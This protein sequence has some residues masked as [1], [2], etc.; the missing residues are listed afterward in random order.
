M[1]ANKLCV[2]LISLLF[3]G[4]AF[5]DHCDDLDAIENEKGQLYGNCYDE[6]AAQY[7]PC[8]EACVV[9]CGDF[10]CSSELNE[11][12]QAIANWN[13]CVQ[14]ST[15]VSGP[16]FVGDWDWGDSFTVS[17]HFNKHA[18]GYMWNI[19]QTIYCSAISVVWWSA[20]I[21]EQALD[22]CIVSVSNITQD[23]V[24]INVP[25]WVCYLWS[26]SNDAWSMTFT[27]PW[28]PDPEPE[29]DPESDP[30]PEIECTTPAD[31]NLSCASWWWNYYYDQDIECC[32]EG[33]W[34]YN[35][36]DE[37]WNCE[38][39]FW[40]DENNCCAIDSC[41]ARPWE[42]WC[43]PWFAQSWDCCEPAASVCQWE[44]QYLPDGW[45]SASDCTWCTEW[46]IPNSNHTKCVCDSSVKCC[47]IQLNTVVP[48]IWDCIE[49]DT[50]SSRWDTTSVNSV[51]AFPI[52]MQWLMKILMSVIM[53][54]SFIMVIV[55][56]L[57]MTAWAFKSSSFDKWK[58]ILKN[59][60]I[61]LILLWCSW[62]ILSLI[63]PSFFGG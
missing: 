40:P 21:N 14:N 58:S 63:N 42:S 45:T 12:N 62:L 31:E 34:C 55:S 22:R 8:D 27:R 10:V 38:A 39:G 15:W 56:W 29:P 28:E 50:D 20:S 49:L 57:M 60:L 43:Q 53:V 25:H 4:F 19:N 3:F 30:E 54:F 41:S 32:V 13:N 7:V 11:R 26:Y 46:T 37:S 35:Q 2:L 48:F 24:T 52:L 23:S 59:V 18:P 44:N 17:V 33:E 61:S 47:W 9:Q 6:C 51:T 5:A 1:K 36:P 16:E